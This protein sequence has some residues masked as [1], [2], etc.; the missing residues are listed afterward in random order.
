MLLSMAVMAREAWTDE[1]LDDLNTRVEK[2]FDREQRSAQDEESAITSGE[3]HRS[4]SKGLG[5]AA[6]PF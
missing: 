2:G 6:A 1:R 5:G 4:S 3:I